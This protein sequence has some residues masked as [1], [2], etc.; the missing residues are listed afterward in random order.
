M[1]LGLVQLFEVVSVSV[2]IVILVN[3][4]YSSRVSSVKGQLVS[5][6]ANPLRGEVIRLY[7]TVSES[8]Q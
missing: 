3:V 7:K 2:V 1:S 5:A 4:L 6:M 8:S